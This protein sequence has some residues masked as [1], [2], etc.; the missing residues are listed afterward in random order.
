MVCWHWLTGQVLLKRGKV[1]NG[2]H[3]QTCDD[4]HTHTHV[5]MEHTKWLKNVTLCALIR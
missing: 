2:I 3:A 1:I 4:T 5:M